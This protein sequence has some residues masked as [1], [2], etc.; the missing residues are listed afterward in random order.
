VSL[1]VPVLVPRYFA[2]GAAPF[3]VFA[4][5][6]LGLLS[7]LRFAALTAAFAAIFLV[8]LTPYY[9]YET[10]PRWDLVASELAA[11]A[12][13]GD[14]VLVD[15]YYAYSVLSVFAARAGLDQ[16]QV[17]LTW[18]P[19]DPASIAPG[20]KLWAVYGRTGQAAK[21]QSAEQFLD[22]LAPLG[23][24]VAEH[25]VGRYIVLWRFKERQATLE[26]PPQPRFE[27]FAS[28]EPRP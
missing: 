22:A 10:K 17:A 16:H 19:P 4:G 1:V 24:P 15:S 28:E 5:A 14:V 20:H 18:Q 9:R 23:Y 6:G 2:W 7:G 26:T 12:E 11:M 21:R 25:S 13:P 27:S 8:N 3:F